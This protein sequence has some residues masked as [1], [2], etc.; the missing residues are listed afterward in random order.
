MKARG[1]RRCSPRGPA[2]RRAEKAEHEAGRQKGVKV[3]IEGGLKSGALDSCIFP[4]GKGEEEKKREEEKKGRKTRR[5]EKKQSEEKWWEMWS[6]R[7][8]SRWSGLVWSGLLWCCLV[9]SRRKLAE[10]S[11]PQGHKAARRGKTQVPLT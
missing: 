4:N 2:S 3:M 10:T 11:R 7:L 8:N 1:R 9:S 5:K 6:C